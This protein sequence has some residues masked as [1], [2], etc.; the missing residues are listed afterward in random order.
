MVVNGILFGVMTRL[1]WGKGSQLPSQILVCIYL[2]KF[3]DCTKLSL[4]W[5]ISKDGFKY[6]LVWP[7]A[8]TSQDKRG[9]P[10]SKT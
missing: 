4:V 5:D 1:L 3:L 10:S 8:Q 7:A 2:F 6:G 9:P